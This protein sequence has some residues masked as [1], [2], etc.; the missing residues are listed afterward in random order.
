MSASGSSCRLAM[1]PIERLIIICLAVIAFDAPAIAQT[2]PHNASEPLTTVCGTPV[3]Q[4]STLPPSD[5]AP[6]FLTLALCFEQQGGRSLIDAETYL[7]YIQP[8][9]SDP[10]R[11]AWVRYDDDLERL[12]LADFRR[13]WA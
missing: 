8:R 5:S 13:L 9:P 1:R 11:G 3:P 7:H 2:V 12:L 4:P 10:S 6:V